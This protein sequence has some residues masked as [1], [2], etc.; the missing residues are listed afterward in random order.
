MNTQIQKGLKIGTEVSSV[1]NW[2]MSANSTQPEV[3]KGATILMS[4]DRAAY[5]VMSVSNNGKRVIVKRCLSKRI[6]KNGAFTE[7]QTYDYSKLSECEEVIVWRH[8]AWR[9]ETKSIYFTEEFGKTIGHS[10]FG[11]EMHKRCYPNGTNVL[12]EIIPNVTEMK[13]EYYK[14]SIIWGVQEEYRDPTF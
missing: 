4:S 8:N 14:V 5:Q 2:M 9:R 13:T 11:S 7:D 10:F 3:G 1:V 12:T 6:D